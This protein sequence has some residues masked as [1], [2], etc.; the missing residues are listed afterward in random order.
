MTCLEPDLSMEGNVRRTKMGGRVR[1]EEEVRHFI[2][3]CFLTDF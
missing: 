3:N 1:V 2:F